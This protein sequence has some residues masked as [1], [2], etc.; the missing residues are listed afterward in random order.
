MLRVDDQLPQLLSLIDRRGVVPFGVISFGQQPAREGVARVERHGLSRLCERPVRLPRQGI[1]GGDETAD[2]R[3]QRVEA[4][5][6][7][8]NGQPLR[9]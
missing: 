2:D 4:L 1:T 7:T 3:R 5:G 6:L 8:Q 9:Q